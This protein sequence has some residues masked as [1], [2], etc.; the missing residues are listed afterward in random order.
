M[1]THCVYIRHN[2]NT[3]TIKLVFCVLGF[4]VFGFFFAIFSP[5]AF[6]INGSFL[7]YADLQYR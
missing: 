5:N 6:I 7:N 3:F 2:I 1:A 4:V